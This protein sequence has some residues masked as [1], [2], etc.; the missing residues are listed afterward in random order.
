MASAI[1]AS[2]MILDRQSNGSRVNK[3]DA[4]A[5]LSGGQ[6]GAYYLRA[7]ASRALDEEREIQ[8]YRARPSANPRPESD[9]K[10]G[11]RPSASELLDDLRSNSST[12]NFSILPEVRSGLLA[13]LV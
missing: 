4:A 8:I 9:A 5:R 7:V 2:G 3:P 13:Q 6:F 11:Q 1:L 12:A 10:V